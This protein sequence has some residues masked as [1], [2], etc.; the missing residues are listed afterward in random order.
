MYK[1]LREVVDDVQGAMEACGRYCCWVWR[2]LQR[3]RILGYMQREDVE[4]AGELDVNMCEA[5][6]ATS[7]HGHGHQGLLN[8]QGWRVEVERELQVEQFRRS[9]VTKEGC[10]AMETLYRSPID[11]KVTDSV[12]MR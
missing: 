6:C 5:W 2:N 3:G 1:D 9:K 7:E 11:G 4:C 10:D 12:D 8:G